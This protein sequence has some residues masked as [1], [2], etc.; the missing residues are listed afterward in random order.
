MSYFTRRTLFTTVTVFGGK[1]TYTVIDPIV[2]QIQANTSIQQLRNSPTA[3][4]MLSDPQVQEL[5]ANPELLALLA[6]SNSPMALG[7]ALPR[8]TQ[9]VLANTDI[10]SLLAD[11]S[12]L[13]LISDPRTLSLLAD[14]TAL[15]VVQVPVLIREELVATGGSSDKIILDQTTATIATD[16][17]EELDGFPQTVLSLVVDRRTK[18]HLEGTQDGRTGGLSFPFDVQADQVYPLWVS[19]ANQPVVARYVKTENID[20]LEVFVFKIHEQDNLSL[21]THPSLGLPLILDSDITIRVE[22]LSGRVVGV[23]DHAT[24]VSLDHPQQGKLPLFVSD[25]AYT[26][27]TVDTQIEA[28]KGDRGKLV[29][30]G[31]YLP[32]F[33][34]SLGG[35][36]TLL[37]AALLLSRWR[38]LPGYRPTRSHGG[39][40]AGAPRPAH[41]DL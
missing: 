4:A 33:A 16:T 11:P 27:E 8:G 19:A 24:T 25:L 20:G 10:Q 7:Q 13:Q 30:F 21:G 39:R 40:G 15:S 38:T 22:P 14:P 32:R 1:V 3:M 12:A 34:M 18:V 23:E 28:A 6:D 5:L 35:F 31:A 9:T 2:G 37:G 29:W 17:G 41:M 26:R 36:M